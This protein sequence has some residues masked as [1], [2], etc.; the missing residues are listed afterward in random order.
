MFL[1]LQQ[2]RVWRLLFALSGLR[3]G[4]CI[5][6]S[7]FSHDSNQLLLLSI[8]WGWRGL[9]GFRGLGVGSW[10][11]SMQSCRMAQ[12][13]QLLLLLMTACSEYLSASCFSVPK[14]SIGAFRER[15][16]SSAS[17]PIRATE[18][19][20][21][22]TAAE[23]KLISALVEA[24]KKGE[25][26]RVAPHWRKY[27]GQAVPVVSAAMQAAH[28][29]GRFKEAAAM[30]NRL[31]SVPAEIDAGILHLGLK[32]FGKLQDKVR[33]RDIWSEAE[34]LGLVNKIIAGARVDAA[35]E[36]G[37][38]TGAATVLDNMERRSLEPNIINFQPSMLARILTIASVMMQLCT[39]SR[40]CVARA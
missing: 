35:A 30:Y 6:Q 27:T 15:E 2:R 8:L 21:D 38:F 36:I 39:S 26:M 33:V 7:R 19:L 12:H 3:L 29:C 32:T 37:D 13:R 31:R 11:S 1:R 34:E 16:G 5:I 22:I 40:S 25:W 17:V 28:R 18:K 24:G 10:M 23:K 9:V 14:Q 20:K 4:E